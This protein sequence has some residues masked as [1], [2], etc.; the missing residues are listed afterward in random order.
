M[1]AKLGGSSV[2]NSNLLYLS[3]S[4][5]TS[6]NKMH[7]ICYFWISSQSNCESPASLLSLSRKKERPEKFKES[8]FGALDWR[9][10]NVETPI[11][12]FRTSGSIRRIEQL[13]SRIQ[14]ERTSPY[15]RRS[16]SFSLPVR[17]V[18]LRGPICDRLFFGG[19]AT[20]RF[21]QKCTFGKQLFKLVDDDLGPSSTAR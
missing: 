8:A 11:R 21:G 20:T 2:R 1:L 5:R 4:Q 17:N 10:S 3:E 19:A 14:C 6:K 13:G 15:T 12:R 16:G 7:L 9:T 18:K